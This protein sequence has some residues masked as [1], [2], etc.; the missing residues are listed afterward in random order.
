MT[1]CPSP[2]QL[3][4][5][6]AEEHPPSVGSAT[7]SLHVES[8]SRCQESLEQLTEEANRFADGMV[9]A[10]QGKLQPSDLFLSQLRATVVTPPRAAAPPP[11]VPGYEI[12]RE[13]GRGGMGVVYQAR[14]LGLNRVVALKMLLDG[15]HASAEHLA[16]FRREAAA[17]A[18]LRHPQFVQIYEIAEG[19]GRPYF[20]MEYLGGG[21]LAQRLAGKPQ[22]PRAAAGLVAT[23]ARAMHA[24]HEVG[25]VHRDLKPANILLADPNVPFEQPDW[26]PAIKIADFGLAKQLATPAASYGDGLTG[27]SVLLGSPSY[28]AP[29]Q[30]APGSK[31]R[32][33]SPI[34]PGADVY[35]L[36]AILYEAL[37]GRPPFRA[38][39]PLETVL[40][41]LHEEP[42]APTRLSPGV[43]RDLETICLTCLHKEPARR[44]NGAAALVDDLNRFLAGEPITARPVRAW[45]RAWK[46]TRRRPTLAALLAVL[47]LAAAGLL[48]G[49]FWYNAQLRDEIA[50]RQEQQSRADDNLLQAL[51][52]V[53]EMVLNLG[54]E[55]LAQL[56]D[57]EEV[58][59][60]LL[61]RARDFYQGFLAHKDNPTPDVRRGIGRASWGLGLIHQW[62][63]DSAETERHYRDALAVQEQLV[64]E[65]PNDALH[66]ADLAATCNNLGILGGEG[67]RPEEGEALI[68]RGLAL[69]AALADE[70]PDQSRYR[71][72][73]ATSYH[74][75]GVL[76]GWTTFKA[77][78]ARAA[79]LKAAALREELVR[80]EPANPASRSGLASTYINLV[81]VHQHLQ[82]FEE[83]FALADKATILLRKLREEQPRNPGLAINLAN[84]AINRGNLA[85]G[86]GQAEA[87]LESYT[88]AV[89]ILEALHQQAP[90]LSYGLKKSLATAHGGC[91]QALWHLNC[92]AESAPHWERF[93]ELQQYPKPEAYQVLYALALAEAGRIAH[94][95]AAADAAVKAQQI[96]PELL[97]TAARV[98]ARAAAAAELNR[99]LDSATRHAE[100][101]RHALRAVAL[102]EQARTAGY[103]AA[104][105]TLQEF[106][107][108]SDFDS[109][110]AR[111]DFRVL[112]QAAGTPR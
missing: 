75:L 20:S 72:N 64:Q 51:G 109:L 100:V 32:P 61:N 21:S 53:E 80:T 107:A 15:E 10:A 102:L 47:V 63:G 90:D 95:A 105:H 43:P 29:E 101:D 108:E 60:Q 68:Q 82:E 71:N 87:A 103:F 89:Q 45:E 85:R 106:N 1:A 110:R 39:T 97:Y 56:G 93:L 7:W 27:S 48:F 2:E 55:Q 26:M 34:G 35:A 91:A 40:Q 44:Y 11:V 50:R 78:E 79:F 65:F 111:D 54:L 74:T 16:R 86:L 76:H 6:L 19:D 52:V 104:P 25:I 96:D 59:K 17:V 14:Q 22:E 99:D 46:W 49:S 92:R 28:M 69:R 8:C 42:V 23:L 33:R 84:A 3:R 62:R 67:K 24:A 112:H 13:L 41:V 81:L 31:E 70:F 9:T 37:T 83:A 58:R 98:H 88:S 36:G 30:A 38:A 5:L 94:A 4:L 66:R 77:L 12:L 18:Q 73:L 57:A